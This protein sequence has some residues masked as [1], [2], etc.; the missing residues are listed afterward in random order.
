MAVLGSIMHRLGAIGVCCC[1][2]SAPT[3]QQFH[4][5]S[6][7]LFDGVTHWLGTIIIYYSHASTLISQECYHVSVSI[8]GCVVHW[9]PARLPSCCR[10]PGSLSDQKS[11]HW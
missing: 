5:R 4:N 7:S 1:Y 2:T 6:E 8:I 10:Y 9:L 3:S 11:R